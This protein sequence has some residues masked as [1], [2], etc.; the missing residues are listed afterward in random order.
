MAPSDIDTATYIR[1]TALEDLARSNN[2]PINPWI[3]RRPPHLAHLLKNDPG[4][5]FVAESGGLVVGFAMGFVRGDIWFLAQLF[6]QPEVHSLGIGAALL[7]RAQD[8][9]RDAGARIVAVVA[10]SSDAAQSLYMRHGMFGTAIGYGIRGPVDALS[11]LPAPDGN[12]KLVV[13]CHGWQDRIS[14]LDAQVYGAERRAEHEMYLNEWADSNYA[15]ALTRDSDLIGY[16]YALDTG[17]IGPIAAI[18]PED[19]LPLLRV[20]GD[21]L[22]EREVTEASAYVVS[23]NHTVMRALLDGGW[24]TTGRTYLLAS[25]PFGEFDRYIPSGGLLL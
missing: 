18:E 4:G 2:R 23:T 24:K 8:A 13:D 20:A 10:S 17:Y 16:G 11:A 7:K 22:A 12:R 19:Q 5:S 9:G 1:K 3:A 6:V 21:W 15:F 14:A 25:E